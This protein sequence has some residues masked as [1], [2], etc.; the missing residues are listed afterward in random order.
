VAEVD[1][2]I[3]AWLWCASEGRGPRHSSR[4]KGQPGRLPDGKA[5]GVS[6][7]VHPWLAPSYGVLTKGV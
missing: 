5:A 2:D 4:N 3:T 6:G 7:P 1:T